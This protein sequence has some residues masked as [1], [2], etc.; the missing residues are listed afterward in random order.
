VINRQVAKGRQEQPLV[1]FWLLSPGFWLL[2]NH[3][4]LY[5]TSNG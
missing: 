1:L 4:M 5:F 2:N 3:F